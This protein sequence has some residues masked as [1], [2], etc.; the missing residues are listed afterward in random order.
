MEPKVNSIVLQCGECAWH[1][2]LQDKEN[3]IYTC[4]NQACSMYGTQYALIVNFVD[5]PKPVF[6]T[7][8][9]PATTPKVSTAAVV[10]VD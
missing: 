2:T 5:I 1:M 7:P 3:E 8:V 9:T 4:P 10:S 6:E